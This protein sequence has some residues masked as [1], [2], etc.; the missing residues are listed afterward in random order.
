[1]TFTTPMRIEPRNTHRPQP[2]LSAEA[3][4]V[5]SAVQRMSFD[6]QLV[7]A[8]ADNTEEGIRTL[9]N[10]RQNYLRNLNLPDPP[11]FRISVITRNSPVAKLIATKEETKP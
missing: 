5:I 11:P 4:A 8:E 7:I 9:N 6:Q 3:A 2:I 10:L 1:M